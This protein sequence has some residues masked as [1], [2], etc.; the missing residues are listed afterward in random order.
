MRPRHDDERKRVFPKVLVRHERYPMNGLQESREDSQLW[1][2]TRAAQF[3]H[4]P[5]RHKDE[6]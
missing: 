3:V 2:R 6:S 5:G 1:P 4:S